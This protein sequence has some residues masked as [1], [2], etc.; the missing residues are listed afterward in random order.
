MTSPM[1]TA[2][3]SAVLCLGNGY[4]HLDTKINSWRD[5][6]TYDESCSINGFFCPSKDVHSNVLILFH[7]VSAG[8]AVANNAAAMRVQAP[9]LATFGDRLTN[10]DDVP[11]S[12]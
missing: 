9:V 8:T 7:G 6:M 3:L 5:I 2:L 10:C 11:D 1:G 4:F 12:R